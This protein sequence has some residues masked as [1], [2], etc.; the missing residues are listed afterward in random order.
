MGDI[1][2]LL[3][4]FKGV[5]STNPK[6]GS[7]ISFWDDLWGGC[8][9]RWAFPELYSFTTQHLISLEGTANIESLDKILNL[10]ISVEAFNQLESLLDNLDAYNLH[11]QMMSGVTFRGQTFTVHRKHMSI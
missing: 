9:P 4:Q 2:S 6:C 1:I 7:T 11:L 5:A 8:V 3:T 10:P